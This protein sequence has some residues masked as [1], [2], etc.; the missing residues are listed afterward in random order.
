MARECLRAGEETIP[1]SRK[2]GFNDGIN[3]E[4]KCPKGRRIVSGR[5]S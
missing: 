3:R 1:Y 5:V 4:V 2:N